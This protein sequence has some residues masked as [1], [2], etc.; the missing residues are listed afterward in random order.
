MKI[1]P[2][3]KDK[4]PHPS[5]IKAHEAEG[6]RLVRSRLHRLNLEAKYA[7]EIHNLI[8]VDEK[9]NSH[10]IDHILIRPNGVFV[11]E[12]KNWVG[13][14]CGKEDDEYWNVHLNRITYQQYNPVLQNKTHCRLVELIIG[15]VCRANSVIA[16]MQNN[17]KKLGI[18]GVIN[19]CSLR[20]YIREFND[21]TL[22]SKDDV[23]II[24]NELI[25]A[26]SDISIEEHIK[27]IEHR[28]C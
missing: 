7:E 21:G 4:K 22:L 11:I 28:K 6:E 19:G 14:I 27:N 2:K 23:D 26:S 12:T 3:N 17:G 5:K 25:E 24:Y 8:I 9:G 16:M 13:L 20:R 15:G 1:L 18:P 10:Q